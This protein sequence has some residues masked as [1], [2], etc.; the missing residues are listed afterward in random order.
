MRCRT[1]LCAA[2]LAAVA[3]VHPG[4]HAAAATDPSATC[5]GAALLEGYAGD[6]SVTLRAVQVDPQDVW[7]CAAVDNGSWLHAGGRLRVSLPGTVS[8]PP[9]VVDGDTAACAQPGN[10]LPG[11]HPLLDVTAA[12]VALQL[13]AAATTQQAQVCLTAGAVQNRV[14]LA[15][16]Q[17]TSAPAVA[18]DPDPPGTQ[19]PPVPPPPPTPSGTCQ[20]ETGAQRLVDMQ[21]AGTRAWVY[22]AQGPSGATDICAGVNGPV[23]A[24]GGMVRGSAPLASGTSACTVDLLTVAEPVAL[25]VQTTASGTPPAVCVSLLGIAETAT[26]GS[27]PTWLPDPGTP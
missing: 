2:L 27:N 20:S 25:A 21:I 16:P 12:G 24:F 6:V 11:P 22:T 23:V 5:P 10:L 9:P 13:D 8:L 26:T 3:A 17:V 18:F 14:L 7:V 15:L 19:Q 1:L 4:A